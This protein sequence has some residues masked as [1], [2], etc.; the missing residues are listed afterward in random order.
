MMSFDFWTQ[1]ISSRCHVKYTHTWWPRPSTSLCE[2]LVLM[3]PFGIVDVSILLHKF[4]FRITSNVVPCLVLSFPL[5]VWRNHSKYCH[6][7]HRYTSL[8]YM[9]SQAHN[10]IK[11]PFVSNIRFLVVRKKNW[12]KLIKLEER[13]SLYRQPGSPAILPGMAGLV[14]GPSRVAPRPSWP[15]RWPASPATRPATPPA[16]PAAPFSLLKFSC[17]IFFLLFFPNSS[18][19]AMGGLPNSPSSHPTQD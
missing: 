3:N 15:A 9:S 4:H 16:W 1:D 11:G 7:M 8:S 10:Y 14:S 17:W 2:E 5:D 18:Q 13:G 12:P 6:I 19:P